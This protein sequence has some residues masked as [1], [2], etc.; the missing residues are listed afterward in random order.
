ML[1][2]QGYKV[3]KKDISNLH[4]VKGILNVKPYIPSV[5]VKPQFVTRYPVFLED[6]DYLYVPKHYGIGEFGPITESQRDVPKTDPSYW[7]FSGAIGENQ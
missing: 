3:N 7:E 6:K 5:F 2:T 1:T 4:H